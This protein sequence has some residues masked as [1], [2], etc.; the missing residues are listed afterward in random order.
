MMVLTPFLCLFSASSLLPSGQKPWHAI[1]W[2][3]ARL[4]PLFTMQDR[5][6]VWILLE[7][8]RLPRLDRGV[9]YL[10][11]SALSSDSIL[12]RMNPS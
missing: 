5:H 12:Q 10:V 4:F 9:D 6:D 3:V 2:W 8:A 7:S 11:G 1:C